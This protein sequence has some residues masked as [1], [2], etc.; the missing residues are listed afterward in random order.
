LLSE[1]FV[2]SDKTK[3]I[4]ALKELVK[5][6]PNTTAAAIAVIAEQLLASPAQ[7]DP[8]R[9]APVT[10]TQD[11][12]SSSHDASRDACSEPAL[13]GVNWQ[14]CYLRGAR[15]NSVDLTGAYLTGADLKA[16]ALWEADL[17]GASLTGTNLRGANLRGANL[18]NANL[19]KADLTGA[20]LRGADLTGATWVD[21]R[22]CAEGSVGECK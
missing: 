16:A 22:R 4:A 19:T 3:R 6:A 7:S 13:P 18:T 20:N 5:K 15:L 14:G 1:A 11:P 9:V 21:G 12:L 10:S 8:A 17:R 2:I